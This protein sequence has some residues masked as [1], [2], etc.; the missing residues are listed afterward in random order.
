MTC[1]GS[2]FFKGIVEEPPGEAAKEGTACGEMLQCN[3]EGRDPGTHATNGVM[4]DSDMKFYTENF[5]NDIR[6]RAASKVLCEQR[7]DW[8]TRSGI[9][10]R[11]QSDV[12]YIDA[13][14]RLCIDDL[15]YGW[16]IVEVKDN[17]QLLGYAIGEVIRRNIMF[18][19]IVL[20]I[21]QPRPHHELGPTREWI[22]SYS[23]LLSYK[24]RIEERMMEIVAGRQDLVTS[25]HCRYCPAATVCPAFNKAFYRGVEVVHE[26]VQDSIDEKE[27]AFQLD[28]ITRVKEVMKIKEDSL[29]SLA[30]A[31]IGG[32]KVI[33][34][35]VTEQNF[36]HRKWNNKIDP[37]TIEILT[38]KNIMKAPEMLSPAQAELAGVPKEFVASFVERPPLGQKL[39]K[40][41]NSDIGN[42]IFGTNQPTEKQ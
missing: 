18:E 6:S 39:V 24:E 14:N 1:A 2:L 27:L 12:T 10:I 26:F 23:E 4:F 41:D 5:A 36:G 38:G 29:R 17:W 31:R 11:G 15:K 16:N 34:G 3:L 21:H 32:G 22:L 13:S 37:K 25:N 33:P 9:M 40:K 28:L 20:R 35:Y 19:Q 30:I 7:C 42:Q 8:Q